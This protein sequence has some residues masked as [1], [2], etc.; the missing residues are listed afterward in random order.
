LRG[1]R[2]VYGP[3]GDS[4]SDTKNTGH[5]T[6]YGQKMNLSDAETHLPADAHYSF[7]T[8]TRTEKKLL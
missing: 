7:P 4:N 3:P 2:N 6:W 5:P 1:T 8:T